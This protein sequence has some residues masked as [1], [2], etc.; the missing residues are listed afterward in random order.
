M[1][2]KLPVNGFTWV[3]ELSQFNVDFIKIYNKDRDIRYFIEADGQYPEK[4]HE[5][6]NNLLFFPERVN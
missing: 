6:H 3:E 1:S 2:Q 5:L 4:L